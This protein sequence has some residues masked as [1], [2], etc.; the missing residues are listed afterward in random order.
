MNL[1]NKK[2]VLSDDA[3]LYSH[4]EDVSEKE[5]WENMT[6]KERWRYFADYYLG[7]IVIALIVLACVGSILHT[8][9]RPRPDT[10]FSVAVVNDGANQATYDALQNAFQESIA[11]DEETQQT[12]FDIGYNFNQFDY[13][14]WQKF[15]MYNMVG[16]L[17]VT[18]L[19]L[20]YFEQYAP[21]GHFS[22]VAAHLSSSLYSSLSE[23]F[24][25][26]KQA[27]EE[28]NLLSGTETVYGID[29][30]G[31]WLYKDQPRT[32]PMVL[33]INAAPKN[34]A[35]IEKFLMLLF[36]PDEVK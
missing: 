33:V 10:V 35:N 19:P 32:E 13:Q 3:A 9:L 2:T 23:Y 20:S 34:M 17:D 24:L 5:R 6:T 11:L 26:T 4:R 31:T 15:S 14:S 12:V 28:G 22:P 8:V 1:K 30:S 29:L 25:E 7:K 18:I 16:D 27:D 36:F 21:G